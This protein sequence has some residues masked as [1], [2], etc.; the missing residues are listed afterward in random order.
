M[1]V[2]RLAARAATA[3][4]SAVATPTAAVSCSA[5]TSSIVAPLVAFH[6]HVRM[7]ARKKRDI[8]RPINENSVHRRMDITEAD[9][10]RTFEPVSA[11]ERRRVEAMLRNAE[12]Q[13]QMVMNDK[14]ANIVASRGHAHFLDDIAPDESSEIGGYYDGGDRR[15]VVDDDDEDGAFGDVT[16]LSGSGTL[17]VDDGTHTGFHSVNNEFNSPRHLAAE[18]SSSLKRRAHVTGVVRHAVERLLV[19]GEAQERTEPV[20]FHPIVEVI[21]QQHAPKRRVIRS[22]ER[23]AI[24]ACGFKLRDVTLSPD[25]SLITVDWT[26][27]P[28]VPIP[29]LVAYFSAREL[30][31]H[32]DEALR[33]CSGRLRYRLS[34][35]LRRKYV[36]HVRFRCR[37]WRRRDGSGGGVMDALTG[38]DGVDSYAEEQQHQR[39]HTH[40]Y[41]SRHD[42]LRQ[43]DADRAAAGL[44]SDPRHPQ[45]VRPWTPT[46]KTSHL[47]F[48]RR[49]QDDHQPTEDDVLLRQLDELGYGHERARRR[50]DGSASKPR[51][52]AEV[53]DAA[54]NGT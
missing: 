20:Y 47:S 5:S 14:W 25:Q 24:A 13:R 19:H 37:E 33:H 6:T 44:Q 18:Q 32:V 36:P 26:L 29:R 35:V 39:L 3:M 12:A 40:N 50:G 51:S 15:D 31:Q 38:S 7:F 48:I 28:S 16:M 42:R 2:R 45:H 43:R 46:S 41:K 4:P 22:R 53:F 27:D 23:V 8:E 1:F 49:P 30:T 9:V 10:R 21:R 11:E 34:H 17:A 54:N 52:A